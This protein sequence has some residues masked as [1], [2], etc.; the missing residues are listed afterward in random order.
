MNSKSGSAA[1]GTV[2]KQPSI[3]HKIAQR[4]QLF[5]FLLIPFFFTFF[6]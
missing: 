6:C 4:W 1:G 3:W 5:L 2:R